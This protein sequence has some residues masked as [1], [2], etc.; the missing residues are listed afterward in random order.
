MTLIELLVVVAIL[1]LLSV[2]VMPAISGNEESRLSRAAA[3][4]VAGLINQARNDAMGSG[5]PAG[6]TIRPA[7]PGAAAAIDLFRCR[8]PPAYRGD[9]SPAN[10]QFSLASTLLTHSGA[11]NCLAS[12]A[13]AGVQQHDVVQ[14]DDR[15]PT[16]AIGPTPT[17][18]G[19]TIALRDPEAGQSASN[20]P[21]PP[22]NVPMTFAIQR[23]PRV[24]G[25]PV[26]L[27]QSRCIDLTWSGFT[28]TS[29]FQQF[30]AG[31]AVSIT[32]DARGQVS[33]IV[34]NGLRHILAG[35]V[36]LLVGRVDRVGA[37]YNTSGGPAASDDS[38][39]ANWQYPTSYWLAIDPASGQVRTAECQPNVGND[40][41]ASREWA[42][43]AL[44]SQGL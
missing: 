21:W 35:P 29:G 27:A 6:V 12:I 9:V 13:T 17:A 38:V 37:S 28:G 4:Q 36:F 8:V 30:G 33:Q 41:D 32:F 25:S 24:V 31:N 40:V 23:Q 16:Y 14:F 26:S 10:V 20:T 7:T 2:I 15:G 34:L 19:F 43:T 39:G 1:G 5:R 42:R 3:E 11:T 22:E 44:V 18:A